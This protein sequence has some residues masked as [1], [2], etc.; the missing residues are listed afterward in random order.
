MRKF[1]HGDY[2]ETERKTRVKMYKAGKS[3][4]KSCLSQ[5]GL[6]RFFGKSPVIEHIESSQVEDDASTDKKEYLFKGLT[7]LGALAGGAAL[8]TPQVN[9]DELPKEKVLEKETLVN[10]DSAAL[11]AAESTTETV[12]ESELT[13]EASENIDQ[14]ASAS[15]SASESASISES[16]SISESESLSVSDS[17]S[18]S[19]SAIVSSSESA[20]I[21]ASESTSTSES[22]SES[23]TSQ[24]SESVADHE[25]KVADD[26]SASRSQS[27]PRVANGNKAAV[28]NVPAVQN[29]G[30]LRSVTPSENTYEVNGVDL[31][32]VPVNNFVARTASDAAELAG[33]GSLNQ[34]KTKAEVDRQA[35]DLQAGLER[36]T[37]QEDDRS[38]A[39]YYAAVSNLAGS[40][41][42]PFCVL[43]CIFSIGLPWLFVYQKMV[44]MKSRWLP[45]TPNIIEPNFFNAENQEFSKYF[46]NIAL[47]KTLVLLSGVFS[48]KSS[49]GLSTTGS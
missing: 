35:S 22:E 1:R 12:Q 30:T 36:S 21:S 16:I 9:A 15:I 37:A 3:W 7:A 45:S 8:T 44:P 24:G 10:T 42:P 40:W 47:A 20:A 34:G 5:F 25:V 49:K 23:D 38:Q 43:D 41:N 39:G 33:A 2:L 13:Q 31:P 48:S 19:E 26:E 29:D 28:E 32:E 27:D 18:V 14:S 46:K 11:K 4:V 17:L 6:L